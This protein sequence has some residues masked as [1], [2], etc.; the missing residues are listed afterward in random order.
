[1]KTGTDITAIR[2]GESPGEI[3]PRPIPRARREWPILG[4]ALAFH[5]DPVAL[6]ESAWREYGE[7]FQIRLAGRAFVV[8]AGP[9]AH[10]AYFHAPDRQLSAREVYQFTVPI[11]GKGV[12]YDVAP[13]LMAEQLGFLAPLLKGGALQGYARLMH[14][15]IKAYTRHWAGE[16]EID[17]LQVTNE[18]TINIASRCL[19]GAEIRA[20]LETDFAPLYHDLQ[21]GINTLGFFLP[22]LPIPRHRRRDRARRRVADLMGRILYERRRAGRHEPDFMQ[23]LMEAR[24]ADGRSLRDEEITGLLLTVLFAG[25]HT[26]GVLAAW[27]GIDLLRHREYLAG[28]LAEIEGEY[29]EGQDLNLDTLKRQTVLERAVR[30][31]E[32]LHPPLIVLVR[33]VL[34]DLDY[35][36]FHLPAGT[37]AMVSPALSHRLPTVFHEPERYDPER[38]APPR[39]EHK[40]SAHALIGFGGGHHRCLGMHFAYLQIKALWTVLLSRF[41][42]E[43]CSPPPAPDYGSWVTGPRPPCRVRYRRR[44]LPLS[45]G[46]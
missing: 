23:A 22:K 33:K 10:D 4:Q 19:L 32:R 31:G 44:P 40:R 21:G 3:R 29:A 45:E 26:S 39:E 12:A 27:V 46:L 43:L 28:V 6:L 42:L 8:F 17:L 11:F 5:R 41:D 25:Q 36:G 13:E 15:E 7:V 24:Y 38:F 2:A 30:E 16:G 18:L 1:M 34:C 20:S 37:M 35:R 9:E 14:E